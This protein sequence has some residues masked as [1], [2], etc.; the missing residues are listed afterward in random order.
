MILVA[1]MSSRDGH[2]LAGSGALA[3]PGALACW[4]WLLR[5]RESRATPM[6][7]PA[8][9]VT[10]LWFTVVAAGFELGWWIDVLHLGDP[11]WRRMAYGLVP[12]AAIAFI[13]AGARG[14]RWP[15]RPFLHAYAGIGAAGLAI[16]LWL[17]VMRMNFDDGSALPLFYL[18]VANPVELTQGFALAG[19]AGWLL[20]LWRAAP[21]EWMA[22]QNR[23]AESLAM[24]VAIFACLNAVLLRSLHHFAGIP[25]DPESLMASTLVQASL[26]IFWGL[27]ALAG[28]VFATRRSNRVV[29]FAGAVL[30]GLVLVKMF[31]VDLSRTGTI[32]RIVSFI[33]VG[34]LMLI[35][36]RFAPAPPAA[37]RM[38]AVR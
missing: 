25:F 14:A 12:A 4:L 27:L 36:G 17:W 8:V 22:A 15:V 21:P 7:E 24:A 32:A 11:V 34:V 29:W 5:W 9:H 13:V 30:L 23:P 3:W 6:L 1:A 16:Y 31:L 28:M 19:I 35:I 20:Y 18:P 2:L 33:G 10:S 26:S 38:E 37:D